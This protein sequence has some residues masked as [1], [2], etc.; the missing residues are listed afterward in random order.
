MS[1]AGFSFLN[2]NSR[3]PRSLRRGSVNFFGIP[4]LLLGWNDRVFRGFGYAELYYFLGW[5]FDGLARRRVAPHSRFAIHANQPADARQ[6][7]NAVLLHFVDRHA[8]QAIQKLARRLVVDFARLGQRSHQLRLGHSLIR[9]ISPSKLIL[10]LSIEHVL[11]T[12]PA[13]ARP[14]SISIIREGQG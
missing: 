8:A 7:E 9:H 14:N 10:P 1:P 3:D 5:N 6:H 4:L 2:R 11:A 13:E 12:I